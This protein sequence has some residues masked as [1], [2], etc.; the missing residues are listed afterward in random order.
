MLSYRIF[1]A[2]VVGVA[3]VSAGVQAGGALKSGPQAGTEVPGPF[4][5]LNVT[6]EQAGKKACLYCSNGGNP[7][8]V[9]FA[10]EATPAVAKLLKQLDDATVKNGKAE[11]GSYAVF[12]SDKD[13]LDKALTKLAGEQKLKK[14]ILSI[15]NPAGPKDYQIAK[16]ADVTVLL[17]LDFTVKANHAFRKGELNDASITKVVADVTKIVK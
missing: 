11:M 17:Y 1:A 7:V 15:D 2:L 6:G 4:H 16:D 13:G 9:V 3:L 12:C 14:L 5:P 10:R 8:A